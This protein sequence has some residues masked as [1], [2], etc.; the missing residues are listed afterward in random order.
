M[1]KVPPKSLLFL[2]QNLFRFRHIKK[3]CR[4]IADGTETLNVVEKARGERAIF[5]TARRAGKN[6]V[7]VTPRERGAILP[8]AKDCAEKEKGDGNVFAD[9]QFRDFFAPTK[10]PAGVPNK[11]SRGL[12]A[13]ANAASKPRTNV[14]PVAI[15]SSITHTG[16]GDSMRRYFTR[17]SNGTYASFSLFANV[18]R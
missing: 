11:I 6:G 10:L 2:A 14:A 17:A 15:V 5:F 13:L 18:K 8:Q 16:A 9:T 12:A 4:A 7:G 3:I 1:G